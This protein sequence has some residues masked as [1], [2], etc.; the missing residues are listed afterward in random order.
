MSSPSDKAVEAVAE[1]LLEEEFPLIVATDALNAAHDP[2]LGL[3]RSVC[4]RDV[5]AVIG[6]DDPGWPELVARQFV[7]P[8]IIEQEFGS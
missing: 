8:E 6:E 5:L 7:S 4:L 3:D 1:L 2:S